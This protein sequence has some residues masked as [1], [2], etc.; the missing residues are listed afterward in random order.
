MCLW[1]FTQSIL[2]LKWHVHKHERQIKL[3]IKDAEVQQETLCLIYRILQYF[4][5]ITI[6]ELHIQKAKIPIAG[7]RGR[8]AMLIYL[9]LSSKVDTQLS[10]YCSYILVKKNTM[11]TSQ[12]MQLLITMWL[13]FSQTSSLFWCVYA[14]MLYKYLH[15]S[16]A[17]TNIH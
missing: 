9:L 17:H 4:V 12:K 7:S 2:L 10:R 5:S 1:C 6:K 8:G 13:I 3:G 16:C 15:F 11:V 14:F